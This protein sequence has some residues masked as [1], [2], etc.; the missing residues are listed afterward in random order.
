MASVVLSVLLVS[1]PVPLVLAGLFY[2]PFLAASG[3]EGFGN[4]GS[5]PAP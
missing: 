2:V 3:T 5:L 4:T 1:G